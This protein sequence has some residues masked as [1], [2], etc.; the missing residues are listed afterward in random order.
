MNQAC[1]HLLDLPVFRKI[2]YILQHVQIK[3]I[4]NQHIHF[5]NIARIVLTSHTDTDCRNPIHSFRRNTSE[6]FNRICNIRDSFI[7]FSH[8]MKFAAFCHS[9]RYCLFFVIRHIYHPFLFLFLFN[10][11]DY[12]AFLLGGLFR[13]IFLHQQLRICHIST[14]SCH[15]SALLSLCVLLFL[16]KIYNT[17][18][19]LQDPP[20]QNPLIPLPASAS[21]YH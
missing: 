2:R 13:P 9:K 11:R 1:N 17:S 20:V 19:F 18:F 8:I 15:I 7:E 21:E 3:A 12:R 5:H 10:F 4:S 16:Q 14:L 6:L